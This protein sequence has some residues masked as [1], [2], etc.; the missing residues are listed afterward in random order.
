MDHLVGFLL[1]LL[2]E[3]PVAEMA[4]EWLI[5]SMDHLVSDRVSLLDE[6]FVA[7]LALEWSGAAVYT[8][9]VLQVRGLLKLFITVLASVI[10][11]GGGR[12]LNLFV[13]S[14]PP[15]GVGSHVLFQ[16]CT[17]EEDPDALRAFE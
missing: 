6:G 3:P 8:F 13:G 1:R 16:V 10:T 5:S 14:S 15:V 7:E 2:T 17:I 11:L 9:V 4:T 12:P